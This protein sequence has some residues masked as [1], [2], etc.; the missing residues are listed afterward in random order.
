MNGAD[1]GACEHRKTGLRNHRHVNQNTIPFFYAVGL[2]DRSHPIDFIMQLKKCIGMLL[3]GFS[4][5]RNQCDLRCT[6]L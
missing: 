2:Q 1:A 3:I 4:G 5:D 6:I